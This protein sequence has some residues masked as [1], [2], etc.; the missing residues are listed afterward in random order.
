MSRRQQVVAWTF[1][2]AIIIGLSTL[3]AVSGLNTPFV[4]PEDKQLALH[5]HE[6]MRTNVSDISMMTKS[7][8]STESVPPTPTDATQTTLSLSQQTTTTPTNTVQATASQSRRSTTTTIRTTP[9]R[10]TT[11]RDSFSSSV[12]STTSAG[13]LSSTTTSQASTHSEITIENTADRSPE[14]VAREFIV[15]SFSVHGDMV[16]TQIFARETSTLQKLLAKR[17][18]LVLQRRAAFNLGLHNPSFHLEILEQR[19]EAEAA[20]LSILSTERCSFSNPQVTASGRYS[21]LMM[22]VKE[23][24]EWKIKSILS[25]DRFF[26]V[27]EKVSSARV[28]EVRQAIRT[29]RGLAKKF[30][31]TTTES[32]IDRRFQLEKNNLFKEKEEAYIAEEIPVSTGE[33]RALF[34]RDAMKHYQS[35]WAL[36]RNPKYSDYSRVG[37]DCQNYV[38]QVIAAGGSPMDEIGS[39]QWYYIKSSKRSPSWAGVGYFLSYITN[40]ADKGPHGVI[41]RS[42]QS[43][44]C[45]DVVHHDWNHDGYYNHAT[46]IYRA[47]RS[48]TFS[49]HTN[50]EIDYPLYYMPG[51]K[52]YYHLVDYGQ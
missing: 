4:I 5:H 12:S 31:L 13:S 34:D 46:S 19:I 36:S 42:A 45:G 48:P 27:F 38:S 18:E 7:P 28:F 51:H 43:L 32:A 15:R 23:Q 10:T 16:P 47:G 2:I 35:Q 6:T 17:K 14:V 11:S 49:G 41:V 25:R 40:N 8:L 29:G 26:G 9:T 1:A 39:Q 3:V 30:Q 52:Q 22:L 44:Q 50:D 20:Y 24:N 21:Y 33:N 37:G